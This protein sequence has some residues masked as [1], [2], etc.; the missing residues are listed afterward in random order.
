MAK[1]SYCCMLHQMCITLM[2][3]LVLVIVYHRIVCGYK[4]TE[5]CY[6]TV[7]HLECNVI[8]WC[9]FDR[10]WKTNRTPRMCEIKCVVYTILLCEP[11]CNKT[12]LIASLNAKECVWLVQRFYMVAILYSSLVELERSC[13]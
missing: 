13:H 5:L 1:E 4:A 11:W 6:L 3:Q 8:M 7:L 12:R 9:S 10:L 2:S